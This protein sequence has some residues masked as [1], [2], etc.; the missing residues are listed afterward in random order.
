MATRPLAMMSTHSLN[1]V[2]E[3]YSNK[4]LCI[5]IEFLVLE[6][7]G[8]V[9]LFIFL[10]LLV[11]KLWLVAISADAPTEI[12]DGRRKNPMGHFFAVLTTFFDK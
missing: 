6:L 5:L 11:P 12:Q 1:L 8:K 2:M 4:V 10:C 7:Y 9:V 3:M